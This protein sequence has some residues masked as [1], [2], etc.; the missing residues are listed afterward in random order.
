LVEISNEGSQKTRPKF[1]AGE[2]MGIPEMYEMYAEK[3]ERIRE[4]AER[5]RANYDAQSEAVKIELR[6]R[7]DQAVAVLPAAKS[8]WLRIEA[9]SQELKAIQKD[10]WRFLPVALFW[11]GAFLIFWLSPDGKGEVNFGVVVMLLGGHGWIWHLWNSHTRQKEVRGLRIKEAEYL[12]RWE[13]TGANSDTFW[14]HREGV[15]EQ[16]QTDGLTE[17]EREKAQALRETKWRIL[18]H[19][20]QR[21]LFFR[22]SGTRENYSL[23]D[24]TYALE[25]E[26]W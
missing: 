26:R 7:Y 3:L 25:A 13:A 19:E 18:N 22:A 14:R 10:K 2:R 24:S 17:A 16:A 4:P 5:L 1:N 12:Y 23:E 21:A 8:I 15:I 20:L 11:I 9:V 6:R